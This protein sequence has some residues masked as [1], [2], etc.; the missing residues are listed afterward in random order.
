MRAFVAAA[1]IGVAAGQLVVNRPVTVEQLKEMVQESVAAGDSS[2]PSGLTSPTICDSTVKQHAGYLRVDA[3]AKYFFWMFESRRDPAK[4]PLVLWLTGG[5]GCSSQLAMLA[6]NGPCRVNDDLTT[7]NNPYSW[8]NQAS[9]IWVDQPSATGF[10]T[11]LPLVH[12]EDGVAKNM[13]AFLQA[14]FEALPQYQQNPFYIF[15]ESYGGHYVPAVSHYVWQQSQSG[16]LN[17]NL[18]GIGIGN[19]LT[20]P[21]VQYKWYPDM[22]R[23]GGKSYGGTLEQGVIRNPL[24]YA[25]MKA[26][27]I[28]CVAGIHACNAG[29][30]RTACPSAYAF[31]NMAELSPYEASGYNVYDMRKKCDPALPLCYNFT[32]VTAFLNSAEV[33]QQLG[34]SK[35]WESCNDIVNMGFQ[36]DWMK[37]LQVKLPD[38]LA[39]GIEVLIYAGDVDFICNWLGNKMWT[40]ALEWPHK[41]AF[42]SAEDKPYV[43]GNTQGG[44]LR[45][46]FGMHFLQVYQAGHMVPMDQP[47]VALQLL[48]DFISGRMRDAADTEVVV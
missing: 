34:V 48:N 7:Q 13:Y 43:V 26:A 8:T 44:R 17:V 23:D 24:A 38:M 29:L 33:Q 9:V 41:D 40:M 1:A 37:D 2:A 47:A 15:G 19:G 32:A 6:E 14:F 42:N 16:G 20:D 25:A 27:T 3:N 22:A 12:N 31:C 30:N 39:A 21:E 46:A 36:E 35:T 10:S 45:S 11:G 4:D 28:P 18:K 5:P